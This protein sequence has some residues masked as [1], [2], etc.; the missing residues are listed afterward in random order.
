[1]V[2]VGHPNNVKRGGLCPYVRESMPVRNFK[3]SYLRE[4]LTLEV[5]IS[6]KNGYVVTLYRSPRQTSDKLDFF[7]TNL[8]KLLIIITSADPHFVILLGDFNGMK[9]LISDPNHILQHLSSCIDLIFV[10]QPNLV[11]DSGIHPS[12]HLNCHHQII[13][14]K[15][16]LKIEYPPIYARKIWDYGKA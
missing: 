13:F 1:M 6:N 2:S 7:I 16:S 9:Q 8:E 10:N 3:N 4:C 12:R 5:I 11:L 14:C 15:L